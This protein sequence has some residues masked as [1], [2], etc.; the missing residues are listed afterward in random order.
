MAGHRFNPEHAQKLDSPERRELLPPQKILEDFGLESSDVVLDMGAGTGYF[1]LPA[2]GMT[3]RV[4][5]LDVEPRM[6]ALLE[7]RLQDQNVTN[8]ELREGKIEEIPVEDGSV[9]KVIA[10]FILHETDD[11]DQVIQEMKR[12]IKPGGKTLIIEWEKK[13]TDQGPPLAHR[14]DIKDLKQQLEAHQVTIEKSIQE[15][16]KHYLLHAAVR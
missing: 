9:D 14:L 3:E 15:N 2:A 7:K 13:E 16:G 10:S 1:T 6:L 12:V 8:V 11:L 5:A 4:I